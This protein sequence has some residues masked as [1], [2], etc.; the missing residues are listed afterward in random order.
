MLKRSSR[1]QAPET[2]HRPKRGAPEPPERDAKKIHRT[3]SAQI[4]GYIAKVDDQ[5]T[6]NLARNVTPSTEKQ[7]E[8]FLSKVVSR[9]HVF[10]NKSAEDPTFAAAEELE[11]CFRPSWDFFENKRLATFS[12]A[13]LGKMIS[14]SRKCLHQYFGDN[15]LTKGPSKPRSR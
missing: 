12:P 3:C 6:S 2:I 13:G 8:D 4:L 14:A 5:V 11:E 7:L 1:E 9:M 10:F 15:N